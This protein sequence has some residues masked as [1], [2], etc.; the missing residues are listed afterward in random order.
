MS[1][2]DGLRQRRRPA[3]PPQTKTP[4]L[5]TENIRRTQS[6]YQYRET[7]EDGS[8]EQRVMF[9]HTRS[10]ERQDLKSPGA[11]ST[12]S[13]DDITG[14]GAGSRAFS[15]GP[16]SSSK[17]GMGMDS[18]Q[19]AFYSALK[20]LTTLKDPPGDEIKLQL[21]GLYKQVTVGPVTSS[22]PAPGLFDMV[23][24]AK[25]GAWKGLE[26]MS[27][28]DAM[29][30]Y[31]AIVHQLSG[32][33]TNIGAGAGVP[34]SPSAASGRISPRLQS[35]AGRSADT[36]SEHHHPLLRDNFK[37][38][39]PIRE[40]ILSFV[41]NNILHSTHTPPKG[42]A[43]GGGDGDGETPAG[44]HGNGS[45]S[46]TLSHQAGGSTSARKAGWPAEGADSFRDAWGDTYTSPAKLRTAMRDR[47]VA[48]GFNA[49]AVEE[50]TTAAMGTRG[51]FT[52]SMT[53][54]S[55]MLMQPFGG[56]SLGGAT[57]IHTAISSIYALMQIFLFGFCCVCNPLDTWGPSWGSCNIFT[58][59]L[60]LPPMDLAAKYPF[61]FRP[62]G[63]K[64]LEWGEV[65]ALVNFA[66]GI[67][68]AMNVSQYKLGLIIEYV[69]KPK[70][71]D[72]LNQ[73][74][75]GPLYDS[76]P[77]KSKKVQDVVKYAIE[78]LKNWGI[79]IAL[80]FDEI[81][82]AV[83]Q[84]KV[85][86]DGSIAPPDYWYGMNSHVRIK[87]FHFTLSGSAQ[88]SFLSYDLLEIRL[89][90]DDDDL[91]APITD[92]QVYS[93]EFDLDVDLDVDQEFEG[94]QGQIE[95]QQHQQQLA[96]ASRSLST[97]T[98][99]GGVPTR[100]NAV[101]AN[102]DIAARLTREAE[103]SDTVASLK[104]DR[105]GLADIQNRINRRLFGDSAS[106]A[107]GEEP[108]RRRRPLDRFSLALEQPPLLSLSSFSCGASLLRQ[109]ANLDFSSR[110]AMMDSYG[111][112]KRIYKESKHA[113]AKSAGGGSTG[114]LSPSRAR[115]EHLRLRQGM[116]APQRMGGD[117]STSN[118]D[119]FYT[120]VMFMGGVG[121]LLFATSMRKKA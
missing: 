18:L 95:L 41:E 99:R 85:S 105:D 104:R 71:E 59:A 73:H 101:N 23:G 61:W 57:F 96:L 98:V 24:K 28:V 8:G 93:Q 70:S 21:Y 9:S 79:N 90:D 62:L 46:G 34:S 111:E 53:W 32:V 63:I 110:H 84:V 102:D 68:V 89:L 48:D 76:T 37:P 3:S 78:K 114:N 100:L 72:A 31:V 1:S 67:H 77:G 55:R 66:G 81:C 80:S 64:K 5:T 50:Q 14:A 121:T 91:Y 47:S 40:E 74:G 83:Q 13:L 12:D 49:S 30:N 38:S 56:L 82:V 39:A 115:S 117:D 43:G 2:S 16:S 26:G 88:G 75:H 27:K 113:S 112:I 42:S 54:L 36:H 92:G 4:E 35:S 118:S 94:S 11:F 86:L 44:P 20:L 7:S 60:R 97:G 25:F 17:V 116:F 107:S 87:D 19:A 45:Y 69:E 22:T 58:G 120:V 15:A 29:K 6:Q 52:R 65:L 109:L 33:T 119:L 108:V 103:V 51:A 106:T 10:A